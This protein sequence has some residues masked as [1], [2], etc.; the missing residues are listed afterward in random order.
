MLRNKKKRCILRPPGRDGV[1]TRRGASRSSTDGQIVNSCDC[2]VPAAIP[3]LVTESEQAEMADERNPK[4]ET[5]RLIRALVP[6]QE[7]RMTFK[8]TAMRTM[9]SAPVEQGTDN[10]VNQWNTYSKSLIDPWLKFCRNLKVSRSK[11][12]KLLENY[13]VTKSEQQPEVADGP[14]RR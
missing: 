1:A 9:S 7:S 11:L 2:K 13:V 6:A 12:L 10:D 4:Q 5:L 14:C 8:Y 3:V